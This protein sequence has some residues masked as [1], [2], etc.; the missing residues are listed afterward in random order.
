MAA[1]RAAPTSHPYRI[2]PRLLRTD[3]SRGGTRWFMLNRER[4]ITSLKPVFFLVLW[5]GLVFTGAR[6]FPVY[7]GSSKLSDYIRDLAVRASMRKASPAEVQAEILS[8]ARS[9]GLPLADHEVHVTRSED[10]IQ[11][12]L[13]YTV[14]I[15][16]GLFNWNLH[17]TPSVESRAYN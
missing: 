16:L 11:I 7:S 1:T 3:A 13:D 17:F 15:S 10:T 2:L 5:G 6:A 9:L 4:Q 14:P 8:Y 12:N